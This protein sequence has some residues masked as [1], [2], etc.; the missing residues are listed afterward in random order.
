[1]TKRI[2]ANLFGAMFISLGIT[3]ILNAGF[4]AFPV[5]A[6][7]WFINNLSDG[8]ITVGTA[9]FLV[10]FTLMIIGY[11]ITKDYKV[12]LGI[13]LTFGISLLLDMWGV[14]IVPHIS[15]VD[16]TWFRLLLALLGVT[17]IA[18]GSSITIVTRM[19]VT[20]VDQMMVIF[21]NWFKNMF[22]SKLALETSF[23]I[24]AIT[25]GLL[26]KSLWSQINWFTFVG[27]LLL[28]PMIQI[29]YNIINKWLTPILFTIKEE[30]E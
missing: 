7:S 1:M 9:N 21:N 24:I 22:L 5:D 28:S 27:I 11:L 23:L 10:N 14:L 29:A 30:E 13:I 2:I 20:P 18:I 26:S 8:V 19:F 16:Y 25:L 17:G 12:F 15:S 3:F 6:S 4:G